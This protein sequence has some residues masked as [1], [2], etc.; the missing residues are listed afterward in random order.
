MKCDIIIPIWNQSEFTRECIDNIIKNTHYPYRLILIDNGSDSDTK[1][2]LENLKQD[3]RAE[4]V[5]IRNEENLGFVKAVNQGLQISNAPYVCILN[6]DTIPAPGWLERMIAFAERHGDIGLINPQCDGHLD[7]PIDKYAEILSKHKDEYMELNQCQGFCMLVRRNLI[8][9]IGHLDEA[10]GIG[11]FDD[12]DYSRRAHIAGYRSVAIKEAYV[13]HRTHASFNKLGDRERWVTRNEEIYYR[14]WGRHLRI[15]MVA[16]VDK[17]CADELSRIF[18]L[19]YGLARQWAWIHIWLN[20]NA[21]K[22][23]RSNLMNSILKENNLVPHQNIKINYFNLPQTFFKIYVAGKLLER[24]R[25]KMG[26]KRFDAVLL[27][28]SGLHFIAPF[29]K[30]IDAQII[31]IPQGESNRKDWQAEAKE[32][33]SLINAKKRKK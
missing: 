22:D 27:L 31:N 26:S 1:T 19:A 3:K 28:G 24:K 7:T 8:E 21:G 5:V 23:V 17:A 11:G 33:A 6:N 9:K 29:A 30:A 12:T 16:S 13:Y 4:A 10:F 18:L 25:K 14:K 2:Y 20:C 32:I 15:G